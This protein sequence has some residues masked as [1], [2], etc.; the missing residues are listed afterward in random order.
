M[1]VVTRTPI[2]S[3]AERIEECCWVGG[4]LLVNLSVVTC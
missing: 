1:K 3:R 2:D 4:G